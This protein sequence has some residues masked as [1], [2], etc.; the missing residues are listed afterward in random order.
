MA[1]ALLVTI[2]RA[3]VW[4]DTICCRRIIVVCEQILAWSAAHQ[5]AYVPFLA[6]AVLVAAL[7]VRNALKS[8]RS[9]WNA[10]MTS[11]GWGGVVGVG[12][13]DRP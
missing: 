4:Q 11:R 13:V 5:N 12:G 6:N 7:K 1:E 10:H 8:R 3:L 9:Y 2:V